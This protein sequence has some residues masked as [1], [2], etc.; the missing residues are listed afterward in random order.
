MFKLIEKSSASPFKEIYL[1]F[2]KLFNKK[3]EI[4]SDDFL[5]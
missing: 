4:K 5:Q 1:F 3:V 2:R